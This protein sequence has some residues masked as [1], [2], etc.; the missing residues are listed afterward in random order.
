M[1][2]KPRRSRI[3]RALPDPNDE[4][5]LLEDL[6]PTGEVKGGTIVFGMGEQP[7]PGGPRETADDA[8]MRHPPKYTTDTAGNLVVDGT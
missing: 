4:I 5:I 1:K 7:D 2:R 8:R 3:S 6:A